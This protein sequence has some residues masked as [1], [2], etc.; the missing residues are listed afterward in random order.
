MRS[1]FRALVQPV[2]AVALVLTV[3]LVAAAPAVW[4]TISQAYAT[5]SAI[6]IGSLVALDE[7]S[8]GTVVVADTN[9]AERLFGVVVPPTSSSISLGGK[10]STGQV[11]VATSGAA[12]TLVST[13]GGEV[14][15]G[16]R[17]AVSVIAGVGQKASGEV[18]IIGTAQAGL[19]D[20]T[21]GVAKRTVEDET[22]AKREVAI[23]QIPVLIA[24]ATNNSDGLQGAVVPNWVQDFSN[25]LAGKI[26][27]PVRIIIAGLI[28]IVALITVATLLYSAVRNSIISIGR[29][30]LSRGSV[31]KGL[32]QV[33]LIA[34][35]ILAAALG[36]MYVVIRL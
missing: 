30:P 10:D 1:R 31:L 20:S 29:N 34:A 3:G 33:T 4:A 11:Q 26:V 21:T 14:K 28:L 19:S 8:P 17:I 12:S 2:V 22:G 9:T 18:R 16:D 27:S 32:L 13:A 23:G 25:D 15:V 36:A 5:T 6:P 24:V 35:G 7:K